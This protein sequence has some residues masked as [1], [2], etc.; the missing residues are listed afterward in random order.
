MNDADEGGTRA[1]QTP[2]RSAPAAVPVPIVPVPIVPVRTPAASPK[3]RRS[4]TGLRWRLGFVAF[5][6]ALLVGGYSM[7]GRAVPLP[8]WMVAEVESRLNRALSPSLPGAALA[9]GAVNLTLD[10]DFVPRLL[11]EDVRLL[12]T[13]GAALLTLPE[14]RLTLQGRALVS[15]EAR[16]TSLR[17]TGA[18]LTIIR[19]AEGHFDFAMG[20][21]EFSP[22]ITRFSDLFAL[23]DQALAAPGFSHLTRIEAE[24]LTLSL[25]D[26]RMGR[27]FELGDGRLTLENRADALAV[28]LAVSLQSGSQQPGRAV[29]QLISEK[30][31]SL[32]RV[33]A[34]FNDIAAADLAAQ[35]PLLA[36]LA[37]L[38]AAISGRIAAT[39]ETEGVTALEGAL[40]IG[41]GALRPT[42]AAAPVAFDRA[43]FS[44]AYD[45]D[46][47]QMRLPRM[48]V[49]SPTILA[50]ASGQTYLVDETGARIKGPLSGKLPAAF[51]TQIAFDNVMVD[52]EGVFA[53]PV[54]FS[55][56][57]LDFRLGL[58]P[59]RVEIGQL[60]LA[61]DQRRLVLT[62][63]IG[64][65]AQGWT[66]AL[67]LTLNQIARDRLIALWPQKLLVKTRDWVAQNLLEGSLRDIRAALRL[68]PG[69]EPRLHLGYSF[70]GA[71]VRFLQ[72]LPP[73]EGGKGY[74]TIDGLK[75]TLVMTEGRVTAPQG[76][77]IDVAGSVFAVPDVS[78]KP[79]RAEIR[80]STRS[81][82]TAALSLLNLPPFHFMTKADRPVDLGE[83]RAEIETRLS[84]PLQK[85]I[86]LG[87]VAY[88]VK[89]RVSGFSSDKLVP[90]RRIV[91][92]SLDVT[93]SPKGL[94]ITGAGRL[95]DVPFDVTFTQGFAA[96]QKGRSTVTGEVVLSQAVA[97][98]FGL[99]LPKGMVSGQG[100]ARV[101]IDLTKDAPGE[102]RL[103]SDL[104][105]I[106][107][108]LPEIGWTKPRDRGGVLEAGVTL[109]AVP[110]VNRLRLEA[111]GLKAEGSVTMRAGG[112][113]ELARF[114]RVTLDDWLDATV[115]LSGR[116]PGKAVGIALK[117]GSV[118][119]RK[120]PGTEQRGS[121]PSGQ[122]SGPLR[123]E[124][125][126]LIVTSS[127]ALT[128]FR[129]D[130]NLTGGFSGD[131]V[132]R[133]NDGPA[134]RGAAAPSRY[135]TAVRL[136]AEDAGGTVAAAG[137]FG[138]ARGGTMDLSLTPR[139]TS[140][141]YDGRLT[142]RDVRVR[143]A[144][145]LAELLN[146]ISVVG[147]LEQLNGQGLVFNIA[148]GEFL[149][150]P[151]AVEVRRASATGASLG[152]SMAGRY[153]SGAGV[154]DMEG[155]VSPVY[156]LNGIGAVLTKRGEGLFGFNY[157]LRGTADDPEVGVNPLSILTPGMFRDL[158]RAGKSR[159]AQTGPTADEG[160][161]PQTGPAPRP[162]RGKD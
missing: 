85:K 38:E 60:A 144:S 92:D 22:Q 158:F 12:K 18:R 134:V 126:R 77:Q 151:Q 87:D 96:E 48:E 59:F 118:D 46:T 147:L 152:V 16:I 157:T 58:E 141:H 63:E 125:D 37:S 135:G 61:E 35:T 50:S 34:E 150:T 57:A 119:I 122:G 24:A 160:L 53:E 88:D 30:G 67:D 148:E 69:T 5:V 120:I 86:A 127:I 146:A 70:E 20:A 159:G 54:R 107:L 1:G 155:V 8:V 162:K 139:E 40:E 104:A 10:E 29:V 89:G 42:P 15:G 113:L 116:G 19:D 161:V 64:A 4:R 81:S 130:F 7:I 142:I 6:L 68:T 73:I 27:V 83:G 2:P 112:G 47:G 21:G 79:A 94:S 115:E 117:G 105:G 33:S 17:I 49:E 14:V 9:L 101:E 97:E 145:V 75:Y 110:K 129:G 100:S 52:P 13:G 106:G 93:A 84:L 56:G 3:T 133:M 44:M 11:L 140:G 153:L 109:G 114:Q 82:L 108:T 124:L 76:G 154:L 74:S 78:A 65:D 121:S 66:V 31:A 123:L 98:E 95:G 32:A 28:E 62:G 132:A 55:S 72:S 128:R 25:T 103:T 143:N 43:A 111:A 90:N 102:L 41:K 23:A 131:F 71:D 39:L 156:L 99:G 149:L 80:L 51:L 136:L 138:S 91:A 137:I 45:M 26:Q 36:P